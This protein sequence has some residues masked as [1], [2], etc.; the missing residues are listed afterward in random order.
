VGNDVVDLKDPENQG[1]SRDERFLL[2]A[3]AAEERVQIRGSEDPDALLW[4]FWAAK[5]AA[6]KAV[7]REDPGVSSSPRRY[8]VAL[9]EPAVKRAFARDSGREA[10]DWSAGSAQE[11][12]SAADRPA[13]RRRGRPRLAGRVFTP[14]GERALCIWVA[15][16]HVHA[17]AAESEEVLAAVLFRVE[18]I[19]AFG[20]AED[21]C[22]VGR[23]GEPEI[24]L[25][26]FQTE[27]ALPVF[28]GRY[29][30]EGLDPSTFVRERLLREIASRC[31]CPVGDLEIRKDRRGPAAPRVFLRDRPLAAEISLSHDGRFTAFAL[32]LPRP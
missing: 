18:R 27:G 24:H 11:I 2:R 5:E 1:K 28:P 31:S 16:E 21:A 7:S 6:Y 8:R 23:A 9:E 10:G 29:G 22:R 14:R 20:V 19:D 3:F 4:S 12:V 26:R 17:L 25:N 32:L 30:S 15:A 13:S